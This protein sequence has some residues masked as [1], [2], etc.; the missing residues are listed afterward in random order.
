MV[1]YL[2]I[3]KKYKIIDCKEIENSFKDSEFKIVLANVEPIDMCQIPNGLLALCNGNTFSL[4]DHNF[5]FI[6]IITEI[7][8]KKVSACNITTNYVDSIYYT[9]SSNDQI[10]MCDTNFNYK[11]SIGSKGVEKNQFREIRGICYNKTNERL[12][13]C[14]SGNNRIQVHSSKLE[15]IKQHILEFRPCEISIIDHTACIRSFITFE[16][17]LYF[18]SLP[19]FTLI[20][21]HAGYDHPV[22]VIHNAFYQFDVKNE[23]LYCYNSNGTQIDKI[24]SN[25]VRNRIQSNNDGKL[26]QFNNN[27]ILSL[28]KYLAVI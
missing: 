18:F 12:Y 22:S 13:T 25:G 16:K 10:I 27:L 26:L 14:D 23:I 3:S 9:D 2:S 1:G 19:N 5:E 28:H 15:L 8:G 7:N 6:K 20:S 21:T 11:K 17:Q 24:A 4:Y